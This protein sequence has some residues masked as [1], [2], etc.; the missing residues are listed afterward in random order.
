MEQAA[1]SEQ[2]HKERPH[3]VP[4]TVNERPVLLP[5]RT[6][7]GLE[8]KQDA[9]AQRV[10]IKLDFVLQREL[11][12]GEHKVIGDQDEIKVHHGE[13]FTAIED[14]DNSDVTP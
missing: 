7:R 13:K 9:I 6:V 5:E 11:P 12:N 14:D 8:I 2:D 4:V 10:P 3:S 1:E